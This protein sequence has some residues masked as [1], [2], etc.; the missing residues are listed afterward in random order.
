MDAGELPVRLFVVA[1]DER[2][3]VPELDR[4]AAMTLLA[5]CQR[6]HKCKPCDGDI[7]LYEMTEIVHA[8]EGS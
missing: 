1:C 8:K 4:K 7:F 3:F 5:N 2:R 6:D